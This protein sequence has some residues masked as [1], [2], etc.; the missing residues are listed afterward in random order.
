[1]R[2]ELIV[3]AQARPIAGRKAD[4]HVCSILFD[5]ERMNLYRVRFSYE[6]S[7]RKWEMIAA[8]LYKS[9][10]DSRKE[11]MYV[12]DLEIQR[13]LTKAEQNNVH[14]SLLNSATSELEAVEDGRSIN[15]T[16]IKTITL[17]RESYTSK[18]INMRRN[19]YKKGIPLPPFKIKAVCELLYEHKSK[20][21]NRLYLEWGANFKLI[22]DGVKSFKEVKASI[23][24]I[25]YPYL[26]VGSHHRHTKDFMAIAAM[27]SPVPYGPGE[28]GK[29]DLV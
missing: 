20:Q 16:K 23:S 1:M 9:H 21:T 26:I 2:S 5:P 24:S 6:E 4:P 25:K 3:I 10:R 17:R 27:S 19:S 7:P 8:N 12:T 14:K 28:Q 11:S 22:R 13:K 18:D 29:L 15:I